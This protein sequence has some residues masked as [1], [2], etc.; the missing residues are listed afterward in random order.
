MC[1]HQ[2][3][4]KATFSTG[5]IKKVLCVFVIGPLLLPSRG[6]RTW[7]FSRIAETPVFYENCHK[8]SIQI[9]LNIYFL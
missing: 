7:G 4:L 5:E 2:L 3:L 6:S 9:H 1:S 8:E